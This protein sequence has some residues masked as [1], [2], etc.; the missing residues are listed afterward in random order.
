MVNNIHACCSTPTASGDERAICPTCGEHGKPVEPETLRALLQPNL[1]SQVRD[2][3]YRFCKSTTCPVVYFLPGT[4][5]TFVREDL[6][7]RVGV[8]EASAPRP[9]CYC[10][11]HSEESLHEEWIRTGKSTAV[12]AIQAAVKAGTCRCEVMNP[13]GNCCLGDVVKALK[14]VHA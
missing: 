11:G 2:E 10:F 6:T 5:Q 14:A 13:Q 9:L 8:K 3:S 4:S 12:V 1:Q 7:V